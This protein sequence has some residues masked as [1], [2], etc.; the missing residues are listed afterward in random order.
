[1]SKSSAPTFVSARAAG[2][3]PVRVKIGRADLTATSY[4]DERQF[5]LV[6][7]PAIEGVSLPAWAAEN[8][9][10]IDRQLLLHGAILF[11]G[12]NVESVERFRAFAAAVSNELLDYRERAAPRVQVA[13]RVFTSSEYPANQVIHLHHEMSYSHNWPSKVL[14]H[15]RTPAI[16]GGRTPIARERDV[17]PA[18]DADVRE[19]FRTKGVMYVRNFGPELDLSWPEAFQTNDPQ[20]VEQYCRR[21]DIRFEWRGPERLRT[22]QVR[23]GVVRHPVTQESV[24]F[25][26]AALFHA[27]SLPAAAHRS[28]SAMLAPEDMPRNVFYGD[29][30]PIEPAVLAEIR[31]QYD[32]HAMRFTWQ[33][34]DVLMVDNFLVAHGR[35]TYSGPRQI[36][37]A[38]ADLYTNSSGDLS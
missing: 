15:C 22:V 17:F 38:M 27:S 20:A 23:Q 7:T 31:R 25:N 3:S 10:W 30:S 32:A 5:P 34:G 9:D 6:V 28:L 35:E 29:G 8:R 4:L 11:R 12:F 13:E 21:S 18:I 26:H 1:M 33:A 14:F 2:V 19:Q 37:V 24:F 36:L 16:E